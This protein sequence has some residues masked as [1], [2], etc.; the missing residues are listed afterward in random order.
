MGC[1]QG[2][3]RGGLYVFLLYSI[4]KIEIRDGDLSNV[5]ECND[6]KARS[7]GGGRYSWSKHT[8]IR[9]HIDILPK[10]FLQSIFGIGLV[11]A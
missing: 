2:G 3:C 8:R 5:V 9:L 7:R 11:G 6:W 1:G 4:L 10:A